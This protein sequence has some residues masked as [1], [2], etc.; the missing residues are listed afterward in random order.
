MVNGKSKPLTAE[1][2]EDAE[3]KQKQKQEFNRQD[4]F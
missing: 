2:V 1:G 4:S 3:E